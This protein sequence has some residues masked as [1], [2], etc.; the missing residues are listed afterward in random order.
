M[1]YY[2]PKQPSITSISPRDR[3]G[4]AELI[5]KGKVIGYNLYNTAMSVVVKPKPIYASF[6]MQ[7]V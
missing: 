3:A 7:A 4:R 1:Q 2:K 5:S 6:E